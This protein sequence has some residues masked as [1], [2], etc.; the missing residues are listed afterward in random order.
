[1]TLVDLQPELLEKAQKSIQNNLTR[2]ARKIHKD[3][4]AKI[5][6]FVRESF[7]R[8]KVSTKVEDGV[9]ADLIVE[10]IVEKLDVKQQLFNKL[11]QVCYEANL[12]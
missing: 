8:I 9:N 10:A 1:M 7:D 3:D 5:E 6:G 12:L 11:D 2:V 4:K